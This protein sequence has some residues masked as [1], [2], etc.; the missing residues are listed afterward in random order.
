M[1]RIEMQ[2]VHSRFFTR[3]PCTF[4]GGV[5][6]KVAIF[7]RAAHQRAWKS[8]R[9][10]GASMQVRT[11][12]L[13]ACRRTRKSWRTQ[14]PF[15]V[16]SSGVSAYQVSQSGKPPR[17]PTTTNVS[18]NMEIAKLS[19]RKLPTRQR[20]FRSEMYSG[21]ERSTFERESS[22]QSAFACQRGQEWV[23]KQTTASST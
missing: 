18:L 19:N 13:L 17:K 15:Y 6:E 9:A 3:W 4:C 14:R 10:S 5:T 11:D 7:V 12:L 8:A 2:L 22:R 21:P 16:P 20:K 23:A 1:E